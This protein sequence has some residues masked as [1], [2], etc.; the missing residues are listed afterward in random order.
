VQYEP[1]AQDWPAAGSP[2]E[3]SSIL[4]QAHADIA[5]AGGN[6]PALQTTLTFGAALTVSAAVIPA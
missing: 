5:T 4:G 2:P 6:Q 1:S 3:L